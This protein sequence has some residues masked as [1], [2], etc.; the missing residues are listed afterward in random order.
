MNAQAPPSKTSEAPAHPLLSDWAINRKLE[1][2]EEDYRKPA[3]TS[4]KSTSILPHRGIPENPGAGFTLLDL[5]PT[6]DGKRIAFVRKTDQ[7][8]VYIGNLEANGF[9]LNSTRRLTLD[10]HGLA[11]RMVARWQDRVVF[12]ESKRPFRH[13]PIGRE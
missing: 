10:D 5:S 11:R 6:A 2:L 9:R 12:L 8:D 1:K 3:L 7:S 13:F 4:G